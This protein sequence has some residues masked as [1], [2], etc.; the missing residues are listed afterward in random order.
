[1]VIGAGSCKTPACSLSV[2]RRSLFEKYHREIRLVNRDYTLMK[3]SWVRGR[4]IWTSSHSFLEETP[5]LS[6]RDVA[7]SLWSELETAKER[8]DGPREPPAIA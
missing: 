1:M 2:L 6:H 5:G 7:R 3:G 8:D 4:E